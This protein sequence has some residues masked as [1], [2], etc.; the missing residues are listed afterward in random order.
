MPLTPSLDNFDRADGPIS[1]GGETWMNSALDPGSSLATIDTNQALVGGS[2]SEM[3]HTTEAIGSPAPLTILDAWLWT[4]AVLPAKAAVA[5]GNGYS[6][7]LIK[8]PGAVDATGYSIWWKRVTGTNTDV[9]SVERYTAFG[10]SANLKP[11][12]LMPNDMVITDELGIR[13]ELSG[14]IT[15]VRGTFAIGSVIDNSPLFSPGDVIWAGFT[16]IGTNG[17][18]SDFGGGLITIPP[19]RQATSRRDPLAGMYIR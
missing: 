4:G 19:H 2:F 15:A 12:A 3:A 16:I 6:I 17:R 8:N 5:T 13:F 14:K 7:D 18:I 10:T 11:N 1:S 9:W